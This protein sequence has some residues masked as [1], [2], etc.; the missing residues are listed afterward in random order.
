MGAK[1]KG[2]RVIIIGDSVMASTSR[3]YG[4]TMCGALVPLGWQV[5]LDAETSRFIQFGNKVLDKRLSAGWD[6]SVILL[7]NNYGGDQDHLP[8][9]IWRRWSTGCRRIR[10][11]CSP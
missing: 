8:E 4:N 2:N 11:F 9:G 3:R 1:V 7:G 6:A 5:E 10:S